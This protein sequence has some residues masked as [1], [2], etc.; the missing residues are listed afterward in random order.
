MITSVD[1][2]LGAVQYIPLNAGEAW[3]YL[4]IFPGGAG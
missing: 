2:V 1:Q 4:R 3:G